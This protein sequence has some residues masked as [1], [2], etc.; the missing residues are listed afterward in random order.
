MFTQGAI[1]AALQP[2]GVQP[3]LGSQ[4]QQ[5]LAIIWQQGFVIGHDGQLGKIAKPRQVIQGDVEGADEIDA[6][7]FA[8]VSIGW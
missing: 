4:G 5:L 7:H 2:F 6:A 3:E 8:K 1:G